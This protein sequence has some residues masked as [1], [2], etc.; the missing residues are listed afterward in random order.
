MHFRSYLNKLKWE[1]KLIWTLFM[2]SKLFSMYSFWGGGEVVS[3]VNIGI[4]FISMYSFYWRSGAVKEVW[5]C[6][7]AVLNG[8]TMHALENRVKS[9]H[10]N[11]M[12]HND[13]RRYSEE[14]E[15][16][17]DTYESK[18]FINSSSHFP[19]TTALGP[20]ITL[21]R[22]FDLNYKCWRLSRPWSGWWR[23]L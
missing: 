9:V 10:N 5:S 22:W 7:L 11:T 4:L 17:L 2:N 18:W 8:P 3:W 20:Y 23:Q 15:G 21:V 12:T 1:L 16:I 14:E 19:P 6:S 13:S